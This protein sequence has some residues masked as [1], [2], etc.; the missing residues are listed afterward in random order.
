MHKSYLN[1]GVN[2][3]KLNGMNPK[4]LNFGVKLNGVKPKKLNGVT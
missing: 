3:K 2:P 1:D 4:K